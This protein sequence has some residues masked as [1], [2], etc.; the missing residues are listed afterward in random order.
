M[1]STTVDEINAAF[2]AAASEGPLKGILV[3]TDEPIV[4]SDIVGTPASCTFDS[5]LTMVQPIDDVE[6]PREGLRLVRQRVGLLEPPRRPYPSRRRVS[7]ASLPCL[8][9]AG[10]DLT[11]KR[12]LVRVDFNAPVAEVDGVLS[13]TDDFR[14]RAAAAA[15]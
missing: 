10:G 5:L 6:V 4:S 2:Q 7:V 14:L 13:V 11:G 1:R 3:Y 15:L 9:R 8:D 12:V